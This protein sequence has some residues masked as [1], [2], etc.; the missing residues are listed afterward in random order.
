MSSVPA[1]S[2]VESATLSLYVKT[3]VKN[4]T[5]GVP[6]VTINRITQAW[7]PEEATG[8]LRMQT[9]IRFWSSEGG[10]FGDALYT[11]TWASVVPGT[12]LTF[13]IP[14]SVVQA[15]VNDPA[16]NYGTV[17]KLTS[18]AADKTQR[19]IEFASSDAFNASIRPKLEIE[20]E[21][22]VNIKPFASVMISDENILPAA[23]DIVLKADAS[24]PDGTITNVEFYINGQKKGED[25]TAPY[26]YDWLN[27]PTGTRTVYV[28]AFDNTGAFKNSESVVFS[29]GSILY[30]ADMD[31]DPG[32][33]LGDHWEY[34]K[35][36]GRIF[37]P[38]CGLYDP[39]SGYTGDNVIGNNLDGH[40][41]SFDIPVYA[42][43]PA[44]DCTGFRDMRVRYRFW[45][46]RL[47]ETMFIDQ[48]QVYS[49]A[50][51]VSNYLWG[52]DSLGDLGGVWI[53]NDVVLGSLTDNH[54]DVNVRWTLNSAYRSGT[55]CGWNIDDV[56]VYGTPISPVARPEIRL[57]GNGRIIENGDTLPHEEKDTDFGGVYTGGDSV[58]HVLTI[59]NDGTVNLNLSGS[60]IVQLSGDTADFTVISQPGSS[61]V[62]PG[63]S[64]SFTVKFAPTVV[65]SRS[66]VITIANDDA[67]EAPYTFDISGRGN[68]SEPEMAVSGNELEIS[69]GDTTPS[70]AD[71]TDYGDLFVG[72]FYDHIFEITNSGGANLVLSGTPAVVISGDA[73]FA[74]ISPPATPITPGSG[75]SFTVRFTP[76]TTGTR[77]ATV[78]IANDDS[79]ENPYTFNI[80]GVGEAMAPEIAVIGDGHEITDGDNTPDADDGTE[81]GDVAVGQPYDQIF[82]ITNSG[83]LDLSLTGTTTVVINGDPEFSVLSQPATPIVPGGSSDFTVRFV[84][85]AAGVRTAEVY[86][87]ND[88]SDEN[89]YTFAVQGAGLNLPVVSSSAATDVGGYTATLNGTLDDGTTA[90][91]YVYWGTTPGGTDPAAWGNTGLLAS[92]SE[93]VFTYPLGGLDVNTTY[94]FIYYAT[95]IAGGGWSTSDSFTTLSVVSDFKIHRGTFAMTNYGPTTVTLTNG[96][97]YTLSTNSTIS[98]AFIRTVNAHNSAEGIGSADTRNALVWIDN[99]ENLLTSVDIKR[100]RYQ[101]GGVDVSWEIIEYVGESGGANELIVRDQGYLVKP[102][103][104]V[105]VTGA[106]CSSISDTNKVMVFVTGQSENKKNIPEAARNTAELNSSKEPVF[107][108]QTN[109]NGSR[110][111]YAVVEFTGANWSDVQRVEH[112]MVA[113]DTDE[114]E[115]ITAVNT[116]RA[117]MHVQGRTSSK[118]VQGAQ[119]WLNSN[120]VT[121]RRDDAGLA[122]LVL[123]AWVV[124]NLETDPSAAMKVQHIRNTRAKGAGIAPDTWTEPI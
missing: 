49:L 68:V 18:D 14:P 57:T 15:W 81:Y 2:V 23:S 17:V 9:P 27:T 48:A 90:D 29:G 114:T 112:A 80:Q 3:K 5:L 38:T 59:H 98:N 50:S 84:P 95:N 52:T 26:T 45:L 21:T 32:W 69:D 61:T 73:D 74:V 47:G 28:R 35:P 40:Y 79:D 101:E 82:V 39:D 110:L 16:V 92:V 87:A 124:E 24:D 56:V 65:G 7:A 11:N 66:A 100:L 6:Q 44:I 53:R 63:G 83:V 4:D 58:S 119:V 115:P 118:H 91:I 42:T 12:W 64:T 36:T 41:P 78:S 30:K 104:Q 76:S 123:V 20:F 106:V 99:P 102:S 54:S 71:K 43:T 116:N 31:V 34:G 117:F 75:T 89:P 37:S 107:T 105:T 10:S 1:G 120:D 85:A 51:G 103:P 13:S 93:G 22:L 94:H 19:Y 109:S 121:F 77:S 111:S 108:C 62:V 72:L 113:L 86:I 46:G 96:Y 8:R 97:Q 70:A 25:A 60:P 55:Y 88:D 33:S 122:D 67:D